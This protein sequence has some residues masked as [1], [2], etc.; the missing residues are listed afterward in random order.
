MYLRIKTEAESQVTEATALLTSMKLNHSILSI[1]GKPLVLTQSMCL[2]C[3]VVC[4]MRLE[5]PA[6]AVD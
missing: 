3:T 4:L 5:I 2:R 1:Y 6:P